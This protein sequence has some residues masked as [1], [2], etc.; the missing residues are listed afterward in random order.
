MENKTKVFIIIGAVAIAAV[1]AVFLLRSLTTRRDGVSYITRPAGYADIAAGVHETGTVNPV[2]E[3]QVGSEVSGTVRS[4]HADFNDRVTTGQILAT[5]DPTTYQAAVDSSKANLSLAE[6]SLN[7]SQV[8]VAKMKALL[9]LATLTLDRDE[10]LLKQGLIN[11]TTVDTDRTAVE[12]THQDYLA[13]QAAVHVSEAQVA[14]ARGQLEQAQFNLSKTII[15][16]PFDGIVMARSVSI[17]QTV[18]ASLQTPTIFTLATNLTD[19]QVDTSVDEA[20]VGSVRQGDKAQLTVT[21]YPNV[22]FDGT[23]QQVR[24]NPTVTQNVVTYDAVVRVHDVSG[25]LFP[26]MTAQVAIETGKRAHVLSV[27]ISAILYRPLGAQAGGSAGGG[28]GFG[29][30]VVQASGGAPTGA[31]VAG[32]PGSTVTVWVLRGA[33]PVPVRVVIGLSDSANMEITSGALQAGDP[34]VVA[35]RRGAASRVAAAGG[36]GQGGGPARAGTNE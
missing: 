29:A 9:D 1:G 22:V 11:Q 28:S 30:G 23:V 2:N 25:R 32:A 26:G 33:R 7:S 35:Q 14:V 21:A 18:A 13:S 8:N 10:P 4:L 5:L 15:R 27:P 6:A 3:V 16:S 36:T 20:D 19:M 17:G 12:T 31:A 24:I 34:L